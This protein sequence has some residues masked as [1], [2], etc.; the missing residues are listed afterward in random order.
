MLEV[1]GSTPLSST[2]LF[3]WRTVE[4]IRTTAF[5]NGK[6]L[7]VSVLYDRLREGITPVNRSERIFRCFLFNSFRA[8]FPGGSMEV[9]IS[10]QNH[11]A[12]TQCGGNQRL[13]TAWF[14]L[15]APTP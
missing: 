11:L 1:R 5:K 2:Q 9:T 7:L 15:G 4:T 13:P 8:C 10:E 3:H 6:H 12:V 14:V